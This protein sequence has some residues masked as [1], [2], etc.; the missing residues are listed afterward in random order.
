MENS[1]AFYRNATY[2]RA[3]HSSTAPTPLVLKE[4]P[5]TPFA[6]DVRQYSK[7]RNRFLDVVEAHPNLAPRHKLQYLLQF[8]QGEPHRLA[9]N[10]QITDANYF[11]VVNLLEERYGNADMIRNLLMQNLIS[12]R[13]PS[14]GVAD[15]RRF[16]DEAFRVATD[17]KQLGDDVD[18]NRLYEQT[19]M[20]KLSSTLKME[21]IRHSDYALRKTVSSILEGLRKYTSILELTAASGVT[22]QSSAT[23]STG[24]PGQ[25]RP[26]RSPSP[27]RPQHR[28]GSR[29]R[30]PG[31]GTSQQRTRPGGYV[32]DADVVLVADVQPAPEVCTLCRQQH[33]SANCTKYVTV[34]MRQRRVRMLELCSLCLGEGHPSA[35]CPR[36]ATTANITRLS[37]RR[38]KS[39]LLQ[40]PFAAEARQHHKP[41]QQ[42]TPNRV[43]KQIA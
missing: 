35:Q 43:D 7:F 15:I 38:Q 12:I 20:A 5:I 33:S 23:G 26:V 36:S 9:N 19:L 18:A 22:W 24:P 27:Y 3:G 25:S 16:H 41:L 1:S 14:Q 2:H 21:L 39:S 30:N 4:I 29:E 6:G 10:F 34:F 37:A 31:Y 42:R 28:N 40:S 17:L 32:A 8:L 13:P 11:T